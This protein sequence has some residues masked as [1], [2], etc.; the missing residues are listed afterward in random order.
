M[1]EPLVNQSFNVDDIRRVRN[2]A[3][4]RYEGMTYEEITKEIRKGAQVGYEIL[5]QLKRQK[6]RGQVV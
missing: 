5:E 3:S 2:E 6:R 1:S 4:L